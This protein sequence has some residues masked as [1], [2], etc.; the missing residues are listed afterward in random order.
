MACH[1][2]HLRLPN[3]G[4]SPPLYAV[5]ATIDQKVE[6]QSLSMLNG[7]INSYRL[8]GSWKFGNT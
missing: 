2:L 7:M 5:S 1:P 8:R 4:S 3:T 6:T